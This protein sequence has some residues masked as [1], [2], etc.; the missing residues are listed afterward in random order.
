MTKLDNDQ[1]HNI[2]GGTPGNE[3]LDAD[4]GDRSDGT[5]DRDTPG[6]GSGGGGGGGMETP[7]GS[8]GIGDTPQN[9]DI[10]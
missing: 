5:K 2:A 4:L 7:G 1:L 9:E 3:N 10:G 6:D 8:G